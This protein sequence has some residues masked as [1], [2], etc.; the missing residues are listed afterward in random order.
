MRLS[1]VEG[2]FYALMVGFGEQNFLLDVTRLGGSSLEQGLVVALPLC[3]G[4]AGPL[5]AIGF[6]ARLPRRRPVVAAAVFGQAAL[7]GLLAAGAAWRFTDPALLVAAACLYQVFGQAAGTAW[8]S[9]FGDLVPFEV[10]GAYFARRNRG[11]HV[12]TCAAILGGGLLLRRMEPLAAPGLAA[13]AGGGGFAFVYALGCAARAASGLLIAISPEGPFHGMPAPERLLPSLRAGRG[14]NAGRIL[15][16]GGLLQLAVYLASPYFGPHM[17]RNLHFGY[18]EFSISTVAVVVMKS[19]FLPVWGRLVDQQSPRQVYL[20][21]AVLV[22]IVPLPW[23]F[24]GGLPMA[25]LAQCL[26][27]ASWAGHEVSYFALLLDNSYRKTRPLVFAAQSVFNGAGQI[28]GTLLGA[29]LLRPLGGLFP[30]LFAASAAARLSVALLLPRWV[31]ET[32]GAAPLGRS[33]LLLRMIGIRPHGG[34]THRP[35]EEPHE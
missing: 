26:S 22:A 31:S 15:L 20:L 7:L 11:V 18:L 21:V 32:R 14:R 10:R 30:A 9:W 17:L 6:L 27:G 5:A 16:G 23:V 29:A 19:L 4:A 34:V 1:I 25:I 8:S 28:L 3:V 33:A 12:A 35:V 24:L 13:G 2:L